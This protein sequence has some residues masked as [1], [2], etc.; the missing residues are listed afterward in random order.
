MI[1]FDKWGN[2][3]KGTKKKQSNL[4]STD[5]WSGSQKKQKNL[6]NFSL[7]SSPKKEIK[8]DS[9]RSFTRTQQKEMKTNQHNKCKICGTELSEDNIDFDHI[10]PWEDGGRTIIAN[11]QAVCLKCHRKKTRK[12]KLKKIDKKRSSTKS[13]PP[14]GAVLFGQSPKRSRKNMFSL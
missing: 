7:G 2:P 13:N 11:G 9:R 3:I 4:F 10:K 1:E 6:L 8:R 12:E 5:Y 14:F